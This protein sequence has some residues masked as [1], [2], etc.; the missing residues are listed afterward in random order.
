MR[1]H[2]LDGL[3]G[4]FSLMIVL[5]HYREAFLPEFLRHVFFIRSSYTFVDFFFVLSGYVIA[6]NYN[7]IKA[8]PEFIVYIKKRFIR[9]FPLLLLT[10]T[11]A[12]FFDLIGNFTFPHLVKNVDSVSVLLQRYADTLMFTNSTPILGKTAGMNG[13]AWSISSEMVSYIVFGLT[14]ILVFGKRKNILLALII[15]I[16]SIFIIIHGKFFN[17]G[18]Y[19]FVRGLISFNMGY[20]VW[21]LSVYKIKISNWFELTIP[22]TLLLIFYILNRKLTGFEQQMFG[23]AVIPIFYGISIWILLKTNGILSKLLSSKPLVFLG[24]I[25]YSVYL[26][27]A[28]IVLV[29]PKIAFG[30]LKIPQNVFSEISLLVLTL[31]FIIIYSYFTYK[32]VEIK[33]G[34]FLKKIFKV[35]P[36]KA[37]IDNKL[38]MDLKN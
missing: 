7:S 31:V 35:N 1:I 3:R 25:S 29:V 38:K 21:L 37:P 33:G 26:N 5:F 17:T 13:V 2:K 19:G 12:L 36:N 27:H 8:F 16:C 22:I 6:Y 14:S 10:T 9:L 20:F 30:I 18:D 28:I 15:L 4:I 34:S 32:Y 11:I 23:L 24:D